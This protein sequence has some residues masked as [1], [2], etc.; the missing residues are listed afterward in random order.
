MSVLS[1]NIDKKK[2]NRKNH[3]HVANKCSNNR[4]RFVIKFFLFEMSIKRV[5][6]ND[7][8]KVVVYIFFF[9]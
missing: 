8:D 2:K 5:K 7:A 9:F 4:Y 1:R 6:I 3:E